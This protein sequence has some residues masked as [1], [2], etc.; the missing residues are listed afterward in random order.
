MNLPI[1]KKKEIIKIAFQ[2]SISFSF[3]FN[4]L[5]E[6]PLNLKRFYEKKINPNAIHDKDFV[7]NTEMYNCV[8]WDLLSRNKAIRLLSRDIELLNFLDIKKYNFSILELFPIFINHP[9]LIE[10]F[11]EDFSV[12]TPIEAIRLLECNE[13]LIEKIDISKFNFN[14][15]DMLEIINKFKDSEE[16]LQ[17]LDLSK[18]DNYNTKKLILK[19][20]VD[21][22]DRLNTKQLTATDWIDI[23]E[24]QKELIDFCDLSIFER[25]DCYLLTKLVAIFPNLYY[26]IIKNSDKISPLGWENLIKLD[27]ETYSDFCKWEKLSELNWKNL[28]KVNPEI[29]IKKQRYFIF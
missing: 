14:K 2:H 12:I 5:K 10:Y 28:M 1:S 20:G 26:L 4:E 8:N 19:T 18:L 23:L 17:R 21:Y 3:F 24:K 27:Y 22:V 9:E 15:K 7:R 11:V 16:I 13:D 25:G 29:S 6:I